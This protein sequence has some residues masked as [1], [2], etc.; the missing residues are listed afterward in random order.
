M[1]LPRI[2]L[3]DYR[4]YRID[5]PA[6]TRV[7]ACAY[8]ETGTEYRKANTVFVEISYILYCLLDLSAGVWGAALEAQ[9]SRPLLTQWRAAAFE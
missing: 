6:Y 3:K 4:E 2:N 5:S 1:K 7:H 9:Q 8:K